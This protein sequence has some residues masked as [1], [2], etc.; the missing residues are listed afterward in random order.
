VHRRDEV[1]TEVK[2]CTCIHKFQDEIYGVGRRVHNQSLKDRTVRWRCTVC[3]DVK[4]SAK[5]IAEI[6]KGSDA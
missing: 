1:P 3:G 4:E 2:K 5:L 6:K